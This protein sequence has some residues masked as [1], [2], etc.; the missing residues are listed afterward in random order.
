METIDTFTAVTSAN[1]ISD[2]DQVVVRRVSSVV[3]EQEQDY[4]L[5]Q[6]K[7][8]LEGLKVSLVQ[9][10]A[11]YEKYKAGTDAEIVRYEALLVT[12][13]IEANKVELKELLESK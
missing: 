1:T 12:V 9:D 5:S 6:I 13:G 2:V 7:T 3:K 8:T 4:T 10:L 11:V